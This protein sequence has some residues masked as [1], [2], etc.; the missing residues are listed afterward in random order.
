[1]KIS[2]RNWIFFLATA[3]ICFGLW[4]R[5]GYPLLTFIDLSVN[6][7][8]AINYAKEYLNS[9][10]SSPKEFLMSVTFEEAEFPDRYLQNTI[11]IQK[12]EEFIKRY[13]Y[14]LFSWNI[15]FFKQLETNEFLIKISPKTGQVIEFNHFISDVEPKP[16]IEKETAK[17]KAKDFLEKTFHLDLNN[18]A[19]HEEKSK[20]F[21][22]R[23]DYTFSWEEKNVY[24]P[25][26]KNP[27][28]AKLLTAATVSGNEI[29]RFYKHRLDIP[30]S[31]ER[32]IENQLSLG[33]YIRSFYTLIFMVII[34]CSVFLVFKRNHNVVMRLCK[35]WFIKLAIFL[36]VL[37]LVYM[38]NNI[39]NVL[40]YYSTSVSL[41]SYLGK[42]AINTI[43]SIIFININFVLPGLAGESL[44]QESLPE[45]KDLSFSHYIRS[46]F[47]SR[48]VTSLILF[49]YVIFIIMLG[50]QATTFH[51]GHKYLGVWREWEKLT[52]FTS[53]Y[54]PFITAFAIGINASLTEEIIFRLFGISLLKKYFR[55]I[56]IPIILTS[57]IWG[58]GHS[59]YAVFPVWFRVIEISILGCILGAIFLRFGIIPLITAHYLFD[60]FWGVSA[61][62]LGHTTLYLFCGSIIILG[63]PAILAA[64]AFIK[65]KSDT[66]KDVSI[67]L[68]AQQN[69]N[70][71]ILK[72]FV[73]LKQ[74]Q[75]ISSSILKKE[76]LNNHWDLLLIDIALK[77]IYAIN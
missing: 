27:G 76:L 38:F 66:E 64:A 51:L 70:L 1:M 11:G 4:F 18:Y 30:E 21:D 49:G 3:I 68:T 55:N 73:A 74:S 8:Q 14:E 16:I 45:K 54:I 56:I 42:Y 63:I 52:H 43:L 22:Q 2:S 60:V 34:T 47:F 57:F 28:G 32:Y 71:Q 44:I 24:I 7:N 40:S 77:E 9:L 72:A 15:R 69:Y 37:N 29:I 46:S 75:G 39:Q 67:L 65:N 48:N 36:I 41:S 6:K 31:F 53:A 10:G 13:D 61:Y 19:F 20:R 5:F 12:T 35:K 23:L 33:S 62:I 26:G 50:V 25:W 58:M 17:L 59:E